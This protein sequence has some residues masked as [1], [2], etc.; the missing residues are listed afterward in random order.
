MLPPGYICKWLV[1]NVAFSQT[2]G[3][4]SSVD[5]LTNLLRNYPIFDLLLV[6]VVREFCNLGAYG[7]LVHNG[8]MPPC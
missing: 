2:L 7:L 3:T 8:F 5:S 1:I 4:L 6:Q